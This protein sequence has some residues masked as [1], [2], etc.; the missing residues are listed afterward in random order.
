MSLVVQSIYLK[1]SSFISNP[2][3][4]CVGVTTYNLSESLVKSAFNIQR[5]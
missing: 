3:L 4:Q 2:E 1:E 5:K